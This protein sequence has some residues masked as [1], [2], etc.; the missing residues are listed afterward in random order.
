MPY[1]WIDLEDD[2]DAEALLRGLG[3]E[4]AETP[5]VDRGRR[6]GA[7]Q[8]DQRR[9]RGR[10]HRARRARA[11]RR[12][13]AT[14]SSSAAAR[15][16]SPPRSTP[17]PRASTRRRSRR[18]RSGGQAGT[19]SRIENYLGFPAGISGSE[20]AERAH[21]PG[22]ASSARGWSCRPRRSALT[23]EDGHTRSS[24]SD[25]ET[26]TG[27]T[28]DRRHRRPVPPPRRAADS[29]GSRAAASTTP[30]PRPRRSC[31]PATRS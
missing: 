17:P 13:S 15:P 31:A 6:R 12:R 9:A 18:S 25:G 7:A 1:Q 10:A 24:S 20:L 3:V 5:V 19:S 21:G 14:W 26:A 30:P 29:S 23:S 22:A 2:E 27:R 8:P 16:G 11:R 4:P 28:V